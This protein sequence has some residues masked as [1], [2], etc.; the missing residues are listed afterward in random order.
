MEFIPAK[1]ILSGYTDNDFWF[2]ENYNMNIY[3]GCCHGCIYCDSRS[4][5]YHVDNFD[6]VRAKENALA[7]LYRDI[8]SKRKKGVIGTGA[9]SDPY[10]PFEKELE[11]TRG[12]LELI[13]DFGFG[14]GIA[15]KSP[16]IARDVDLFRKIREHSPVIVKITVT[17][18]NDELSRKIETNVAASSERFAALK[19]LYENGI[20]AGLLMMPI[21]P[22]IEDNEEN[23]LGI[24]KL[25]HENG[26]RFIYPSFGVTLRQNQREWYFD[27]LDQFF[28]G[29]KQKYMKEFGNAYSCKAPNAEH[30]KAIFKNEC[31]KLGL[32]YKMKDIVEAYRQGYEDRQ[33]SLL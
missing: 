21:L 14:I 30:I 2:A 32:L 19:K 4:E 23:I 11:L 16:L 6:Q 9:M 5:C 31:E 7:L 24:I 18:C 12:A 20:F 27:K 33:L 10:N 3:R 8:K 13:N 17:A 26:A 28:P 22:F 15:T 29:M 1:T 25:A